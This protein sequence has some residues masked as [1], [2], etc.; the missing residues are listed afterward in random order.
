MTIESK[1][2]SCSDELE[3]D[4][5]LVFANALPTVTADDVQ[6]CVD[7]EPAPLEVV[8]QRAADRIRSCV[9]PAIVGLGGL[10]I[11]AAEQAIDLAHAMQG[12]LLP[13]PVQDPTLSRQSVSFHAGLGE[14]FGADLRVI[15]PD[16]ADGDASENGLEALTLAINE[17]VPNA[18]F[19]AVHDIDA[20]IHLRESLSRDGV[21]AIRRL[22]TLPVNSVVVVLPSMVDARVTSQWHRLAADLQSTL[23]ISVVSTPSAD[24]GNLRGVAEL[25]AM[26]TGLN[27]WASGVDFASGETLP[28]AGWDTHLAR[29]GCDVVIDSSL[30]QLVEQA[31]IRISADVDHAKQCEIW[32]R[33]GI[34]LGVAARV[35]RFD[36]TMLWLCDDPS[37]A[38]PDPTINLFKQLGELL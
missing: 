28:C 22:T 10:S 16:D 21:E 6:A 29:N 31:A 33:G 8:L 2:I 37:I 32:F 38:L 23:R 34:Q 3:R 25:I 35:M 4:L 36:G 1:S 11:E 18:L 19:M 17:R 7:G 15:G 30:N 20:V 14:A 9:A 26:R 5:R 13:T 12:K 24:V 27:A